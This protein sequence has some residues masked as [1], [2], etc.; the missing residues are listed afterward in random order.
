V[1]PSVGGGRGSAAV[2]AAV[3]LACAAGLPNKS[4]VPAQEPL[5][6]DGTWRLDANQAVYRFER[7]RVWATQPVSVG[8][9][10]VQP[11]QVTTRD[12]AQVGPRRFTGH[13]I[14]TNSTWEAELLDGPVLRITV[15]SMVGPAT[16]QAEP[17]ALDDGAWLQAQLAAS[18]IVTRPGGRTPAPAS[19]LSAAAPAGSAVSFGRYHALVIGNNAYQH[20]EP[21]RTANND[22][23]AVAELLQSAY[24]MEV[25]LQLD[26]T[27]DDILLAL[28]ELR[29]QLGPE[30]NLLIYYAGHGWLDEDAEEGYWLPVDASS[31]N[32]TRWIANSAIT[33][34]FRAFRAKHVLVVADSC[35]AGTLTRGIAVNT[36]SQCDLERLASRKARV[37]LTSGGEE[38]VSDGTGRHSDFAAAFLEALRENQGVLDTATLY[39]RIRRPVML[40]ADQAP[41]LADIRKAGHEGGDF[42]F[43]R[44]QP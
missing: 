15:G 11:D 9:M 19:A 8:A 3:L 35:Y 40:R 23:R 18:R 26:A 6:I 33:A 14:T 10:V 20:L 39:A 32:N 41:D 27:R 2:C 36:S 29:N 22:A 13:E 1:N 44:R 31:D 25:V 12:L 21:L 7:G 16:F 38:P 4:Q 24:G 42:L 17:V 43:V 34:S 30:D 37:V 5:P 28:S